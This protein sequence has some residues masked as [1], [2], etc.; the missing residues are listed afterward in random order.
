[1]Q[2][3]SQLYVLEIKRVARAASRRVVEGG[4]GYCGARP[5]NP[6]LH[7]NVVTLRQPRIEIEY[8]NQCRWLLRATWMA[9]ELLTTFA[10][11]IGEVA[12]IPGRGGIFEI[13]AG[14]QT[15]WSRAVQRRFP[16]ITELK[17]LVRDRV[18]PGRDLGHSELRP[19]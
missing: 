3:G 16:E 19:E 14:D 13:R 11:D 15:V 1:M 8:C 12:L 6:G 17:R 10:D 2:A 4:H 7:S 18:A 5:Q 9:Q